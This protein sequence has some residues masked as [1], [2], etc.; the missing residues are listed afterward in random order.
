MFSHATSVC[1]SSQ[2]HALARHHHQRLHDVEGILRALLSERHCTNSARNAAC[3]CLMHRGVIHALGSAVGVDGAEGLERDKGGVHNDV[4]QACERNYAVTG[5]R[6]PARAA[7]YSRDP[8]A[9]A[10]PVTA[11]L[12]PVTAGAEPARDP[13]VA[14]ARSAAEARLSE[15]RH[16]G[17]PAREGGLPE[18]Q[19]DERGKP[20]EL[21]VDV[22]AEQDAQDDE[23]AGDEM[24]CA[25]HVHD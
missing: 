17:T 20:E 18:V 3:A 9:A 14:P 12:K 7:A 1:V 15:N 25:I 22:H 2:T 21:R 10:P 19:A 8:A 13:R 11:S 4:P 16:H 23:D 24:K 5:P 6:R